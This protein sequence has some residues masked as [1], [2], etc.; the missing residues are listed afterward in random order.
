VLM[1][2]RAP[3]GKPGPDT[4]TIR[5]MAR[6]HPRRIALLDW[7]RYAAPHP[8]WFSVD[9]FHPTY[10]GARKYAEF[11]A[12]SLR[13]IVQPAARS[14]ESGCAL[15]T[16]TARASRHPRGQLAPL[17]IGDS[18]MVFAV[19]YLAARGLD[20]NARVCRSWDEGLGIIRQR[21]AQ[22]R[23]PSVVVMALGANSWVRPIDVKRALALLG[24][25]RTLGLATHRTWFG[26]P[27]PDTKVIRQMA[28]RYRKR[29]KLIDW[30]RY[31]APHPEWFD[32][33]GYDDGLHTNDVGARR[34][35]AFIA[36]AVVQK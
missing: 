34:F 18:T 6:R 12:S 22:H 5:R 36:D 27:G 26:K 3:Y 25:K 32:N 17:A 31:A 19:K 7:V 15:P 10:F 16:A 29:I 1:T 21:K 28:H 35:A 4:A 23:L 11:I 9:G 8:N 13:R 24:P 20:A 14:A 33:H 2:H 30:V